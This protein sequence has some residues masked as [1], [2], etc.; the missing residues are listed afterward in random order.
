SVVMNE[1]SL[2]LG[3]AKC[4]KLATSGHIPEA[5]NTDFTCVFEV[6]ARVRVPDGSQKISFILVA[7]L[8]SGTSDS[9]WRGRLV[10]DWCQNESRRSTKPA[11]ACGSQRA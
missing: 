8:I 7:F 9:P 1:V 6:C 11:S 2:P 4:P 3:G 5:K 10:P